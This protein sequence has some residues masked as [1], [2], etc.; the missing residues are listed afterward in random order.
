MGLVM[1][2]GIQQLGI[3][4]LLAHIQ[5]E[6]QQWQALRLRRA[7]LSDPLAPGFVVSR[8]LDQQELACCCEWVLQRCHRSLR[9]AVGRRNRRIAQATIRLVQENVSTALAVGSNAYALNHVRFVLENPQERMLF[10]LTW[11]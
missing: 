2:Q 4:Q 7:I 5:W 3:I 10:K 8:L 1:W 9:G 11:G 6:R